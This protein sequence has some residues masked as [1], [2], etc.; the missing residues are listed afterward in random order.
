MNRR[1][2]GTV[3]LLLAASL[4]FGCTPKP[5]E[6]IPGAL[7][8]MKDAYADIFEALED[9]ASSPQEGVA[10]VKRYIDANRSK[11]AKYG[12]VLRK[13]LTVEE[14]VLIRNF[15]EEIDA[16]AIETTGKIRATYSKDPAAMNRLSRLMDDLRFFHTVPLD[17]AAI[18]QYLEEQNR[19]KH[20]NQPEPGQ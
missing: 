16:M 19:K 15:T 11:L 2:T 7:Q 18:K 13:V 14:M 6:G 3:V 10:E 17:D 1:Y 5:K 12:E 8:G 20:K 4:L 9:N